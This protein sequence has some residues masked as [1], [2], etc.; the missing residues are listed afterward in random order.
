MRHAGGHDDALSCGERVLGA[1]DGDPRRSVED[2]H[3]RVALGF[4]RADLLARIKGE[5]RETH[6]L[7]LRESAADDLPRLV[8]N[9]CIE[10]ERGCEIDILEN[11][12]C[13]SIAL[14]WHR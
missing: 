8:D 7:V 4:V 6:G 10:R 13:H 1:T 12:V 2:L 14:L 11:L 9:E 5:Q 3:H